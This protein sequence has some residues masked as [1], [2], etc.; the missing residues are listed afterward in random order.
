MISYESKVIVQE[1]NIPPWSIVNG[2]QD[3]CS[4]TTCTCTGSTRTCNPGLTF[5]Y[6]PQTV[7]ETKYPR[8]ESGKRPGYPP[9]GMT[10]Y[11][12]SRT[13]TKNYLLSRSNG[14]NADVQHKRFAYKRKV[15]GV[16]TV[17][18]DHYEK[19]GPQWLEWKTVTH[20]GTGS[21]YTINEIDPSEVNDA[22]A[23][24]QE[25]LSVKAL[26]SYDFLTECAEAREIPGLVRSAANC[27][28]NIIRNLASRFSRGDL[29]RGAFYPMSKLL[30]HPSR[31]LRKLGKEW[32]MYRYA[33]MPLVYSYHDIVKTLERGIDNTY[34]SA[35]VISPKWLDTST[36]PDCTQTYLYVQTEGSVTVRGTIFQ[37][38]DFSSAARMAGIGTNPL[39]TA[40]ELIPYSF[41]LDWFVNVGDYIIRKTSLDYSKACFACISRRYQTTVRTFQHY[42]N[43]DIN[44]TPYRLPGTWSASDLPPETPVT[45]SRPEES[46]LLKE[47][48]T[49][50][51]SRELFH[52]DDA[53]LRFSTSINWK[54]MIDSAVMAHNRL[55]SLLRGLKW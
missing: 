38:F 22:V 23:A 10:P 19:V 32:M 53:Q 54:R 1:V 4:S 26:T 28:T 11:F 36:L 41:V 49:N 3:G 47:V 2:G 15:G 13:V 48:S 52:L 40:W 27:V 50:S 39:V 8:R 30:K 55:G 12:V 20:E 35:K 46:Q 29:R 5:F 44:L 24:M 16:C 33:I 37:H 14:S 43:Q 21:S 18:V 42:P 45:I 31:V 51:Y 6:E 7:Q 9:Y 34:R 25:A 17:V